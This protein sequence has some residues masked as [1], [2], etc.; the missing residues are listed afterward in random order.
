MH[1]I[2]IYVKYLYTKRC[3]NKI[4]K[5]NAYFLS[6]SIFLFVSIHCFIPVIVSDVLIHL[7]HYPVFWWLYDD[8]GHFQHYF[9]SS[10]TTC[11]PIP[12]FLNSLPHNPDF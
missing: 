1:V 8:L 2:M 4:D 9:S 3:I 11:A 10:V 12:T 7:W 5:E 6:F